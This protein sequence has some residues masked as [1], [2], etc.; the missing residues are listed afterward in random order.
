MASCLGVCL[1]FM[2]PI[3][4]HKSV[5]LLGKPEC[6]AQETKKVTITK[7]IATC[8]DS[9][10]SMSGQLNRNVAP[11]VMLARPVDAIILIIRDCVPF[12]P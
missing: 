11:I 4:A 1:V 12:W 9:A 2:Q 7:A 8:V 6:A 3:M 10:S 5:S